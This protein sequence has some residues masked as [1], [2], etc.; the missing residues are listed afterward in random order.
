MGMVCAR[1][2]PWTCVSILLPQHSSVSHRKKPQALHICP[3]EGALICKCCSVSKSYP[4]QCDLMN[5]STPGFPVLHF[6][7]RVCSGLCPLSQC[8]H[9]TVLS[10][11]LLL[12]LP[13]VFPASGSFP[14]SQLFTSGGQTI[15]PSASASVLPVNIHGW[16]PLGWTGLISLKSKGLSR[17]FSSTTVQKHQFCT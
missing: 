12:L 4:T 16:F 5:H 13:S 6:S 9:P 17:V 15:G 1:I 10:C 7:P 11:Y 14:V 3:N 8:C 2:G